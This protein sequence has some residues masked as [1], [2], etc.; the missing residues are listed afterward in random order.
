MWFF[1]ALVV[2]KAVV[3]ERLCSVGLPLVAQ[4]AK[5]MPAMQETWV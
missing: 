5:N 1:R 4:V 3:Y 2:S